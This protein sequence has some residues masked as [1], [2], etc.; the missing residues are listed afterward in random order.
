MSRVS[1][2]AKKK[3]CYFNWW[4]ATAI[5]TNNNND[6]YMML[7]HKIHGFELRIETNISVNDPY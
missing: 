6:T 4:L 7:I 3:H 1:G 2:K 5:L